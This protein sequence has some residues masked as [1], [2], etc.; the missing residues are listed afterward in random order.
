MVEYVPWIR[1]SLADSTVREQESIYIQVLRCTATKF[2][3][4]IMSLEKRREEED[5]KCMR[6]TF[7]ALIVLSAEILSSCPR[8]GVGI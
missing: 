1:S 4:V 6:D 7:L 2:L 3:L 8:L 5:V